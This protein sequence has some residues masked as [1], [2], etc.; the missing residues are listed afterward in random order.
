[1]AQLLR[2]PTPSDYDAIAS[3]IPDAEQCARWGGPHLAFP[4]SGSELPRLI[5][6]APPIVPGET[7]TSFSL[8]DDSDESSEPLGFGQLVRQDRTTFR[9]A[10]LIVAPSRRRCGLGAVLCK[11]LIARAESFDEAAS[12]T[13]FVFRDNAAAVHLYTKLGFVEAPPHPRAQVDPRLAV[14]AM[15][16]SITR[17]DGPF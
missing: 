11:L 14:M 15:S 4:F 9:L 10:R 3:W 2:S 12:V 13:L 1:M 17:A 7:N 16:K 8:V 6:A 5:A